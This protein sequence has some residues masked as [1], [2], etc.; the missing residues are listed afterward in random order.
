MAP[1]DAYHGGFHRHVG[2]ALGFLQRAAD[3]ADRGIQ[4][5]DQALARS[6]GFSRAHSQEARAAVLNFRDQRARFGAANIQRDQIALLL[7]H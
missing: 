2:H 4:I 7:P 1:G 5:D 6:F 3:G